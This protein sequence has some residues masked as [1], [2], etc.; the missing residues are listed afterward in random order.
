MDSVRDGVALEHTTEDAGADAARV[1][2]R[3]EGV[4]SDIS[5]I[6]ISDVQQESIREGSG[7]EFGSRQGSVMPGP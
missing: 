3:I 4:N 6:S 5:T 2:F 1:L 7:V